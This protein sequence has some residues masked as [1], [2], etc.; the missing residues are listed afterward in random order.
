MT[1]GN[2]LGAGRY[3]PYGAGFYHLPMGPTGPPLVLAA[4]TIT[5][6]LE[7]HAVLIRSATGRALTNGRLGNGAPY[8]DTASP[9]PT[10][11]FS[12][13]GGQP[14]V[15]NIIEFGE[16]GLM[17][18][19][20]SPVNVVYRA[21][22][23]YCR[24]P[25]AD[26]MSVE[27][28][29]TFAFPLHGGQEISCL[30]SSRLEVSTDPNFSSGF[31]VES[32]Q[33]ATT[34]TIPPGALYSVRTGREEWDEGQLSRW[35]TGAAVHA[36]FDFYTGDS[37]AVTMATGQE[38]FF[39]DPLLSWIDSGTVWSQQDYGSYLGNPLANVVQG[40]FYFRGEF[41]GTKQFSYAKTK[42]LFGSFS[43]STDEVLEEFDNEAT[44]VGNLWLGVADSKALA[45]A[46]KTWFA[47]HALSDIDSM[48]WAMRRRFYRVVQR[49][50]TGADV[51]QL[52]VPGFPQQN[53][54][55]IY[56]DDATL[57]TTS[58]IAR[59]ATGPRC[60]DACDR[61]ATESMKM[62]TGVTGPVELFW[63]DGYV[64]S[65]TG[66]E[67]HSYLAMRLPGVAPFD[68]PS[69]PASLSI[70][71][72]AVGK[73]LKISFREIATEGHPPFPAQRATVIPHWENNIGSTGDWIERVEWPA[74]RD[75]PSL[76]RGMTLGQFADVM[77][78][79]K[80][81]FYAAHPGE[82]PLCSPHE[83]H[84][85]Q[86]QTPIGNLDN[87]WF[88]YG[89][90][91]E[92]VDVT[93][94]AVANSNAFRGTS[95]VGAP[96]AQ[97][98]DATTSLD[99]V[100]IRF[101]QGGDLVRL[102]GRTWF[103]K[104]DW[105]LPVRDPATNEI[106]THG[107]REMTALWLIDSAQEQ[108]FEFNPTAIAT[109][110]DGDSLETDYKV[111]NSS[112]YGSSDRLTYHQT[113][114]TVMTDDFSGITKY[115]SPGASFAYSSYGITSYGNYWHSTSTDTTTRK[116][117]WESLLSVIVPQCGFAKLQ[118]CEYTTQH[119]EVLATIER[120][121]T[122]DVSP[123]TLTDEQASAD[124][125]IPMQYL[126]NKKFVQHSHR[127]P[128]G[129]T[130]TLSHRKSWKI[131]ATVRSA[132]ME[133]GDVTETGFTVKWPGAEDATKDFVLYDQARWTNNPIKL[134][135]EEW[136]SLESGTEVTKTLPYGYET[137]WPHDA[138]VYSHDIEFKFQFV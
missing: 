42:I 39:V 35:G 67:A 34:A 78:A 130:I 13:I 44:T 86:L 4:G 8:N 2:R 120:D 62:P 132:K 101:L 79:Y 17:I 105:T 58:P 85:L 131:E 20:Q 138:G 59:S 5:Q 123:N 57:A 64:N 137:G 75:E 32:I 61:H 96:A 53:A 27:I 99:Y 77:N 128:V 31:F 29:P 38:S 110:H 80:Q 81:N 6:A 56:S 37:T 119:H 92:A 3:N 52:H 55:G 71:C 65:P 100:L 47:S 90:N 87:F 127:T 83:W 41:D 40:L 66:M 89:L 108:T 107:S 109:R 60:V 135:E 22:S 98:A 124:A 116:I 25:Q 50:P 36:G 112:G 126:V 26:C 121:K 15:A 76:S 68:Q 73:R 45:R 82:Y 129:G 84:H 21:K 125:S 136:Q 46:G 54:G 63:G 106:I 1:L 28:W 7:H 102:G 134:T 97:N 93:C 49:G 133:M 103:T 30:G 118:S 69:Q 122:E 23:D 19:P 95:G 12:D 94:E 104:D 10:G 91:G 117:D 88:T 114:L 43:D 111:L 9:S 48:E 18:T 16:L 51:A 72:N 11:V 14:A 74:N 24:L 33:T 115:D 70:G 113:D